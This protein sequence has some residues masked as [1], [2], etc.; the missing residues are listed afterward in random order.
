MSNIRKILLIEDE[1][2][3]LEYLQTILETNG[4]DVYICQDARQAM[5]KVEDV[6]PDMICLDIMMPHETGMSFYVRLRRHKKYY[7]VPV[8]IISGVVQEKEFDFRSYVD[9][10]TIPPP[11][12]FMEKPISIGQFLETVEKL[13]SQPVKGK[14]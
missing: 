1:R 7:N 10:E 5:D 13:S 6:S 12:D 4:Y 8:M 11:E 3:V 14:G 9:D 2:D